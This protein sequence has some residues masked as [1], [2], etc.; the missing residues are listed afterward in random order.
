MRVVVMSC[1]IRREMTTMGRWR[2]PSGE[3]GKMRYALRITE[4][5]IVSIPYSD[6]FVAEEF[7]IEAG[8]H[9]FS[10]KPWDRIFEAKVPN[11]R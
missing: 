9:M 2:I 4:A 10:Y 3:E 8:L 7:T 1:W 11:L 5:S 6:D